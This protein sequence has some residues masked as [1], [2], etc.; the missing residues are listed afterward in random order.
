MINNRRDFLKFLAAGSAL[1]TLGACTITSSGNVTTVTLNVAKV[2]AY[3]VAGL[4]AVTTILSIDAVASAIG[5]SS[6]TA[7]E[8]AGLTLQNALTAFLNAAGSNVTITYD[9]TSFKSQIDSILA[10]LQN[11]S[12]L[13]GVAVSQASS[14]FPGSILENAGTVVSA[15]KTILSIFEGVLGIVSAPVSRMTEEQAFRILHV[16]L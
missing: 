15:L 9:S 1:G 6:V 10:D 13:L 8:T 16:F 12:S 11:V 5:T 14:M 7:I 4:N 2:K 3:G